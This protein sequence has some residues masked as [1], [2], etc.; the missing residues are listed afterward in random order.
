MIVE[1]GM[2][3]KMPEGVAFVGNWESEPESVERVGWS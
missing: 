3:V 2:S 1:A